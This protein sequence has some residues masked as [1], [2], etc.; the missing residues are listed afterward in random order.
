MSTFIALVL[1]NDALQNRLTNYS[2]YHVVSQEAKCVLMG[3]L[4]SVQ[5]TQTVDS[6]E[7]ARVVDNKKN[8]HFLCFH[9][10]SRIFLFAIQETR[11]EFLPHKT[12]TQQLKYSLVVYVVEWGSE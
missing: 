9:L 6:I 4:A 7:L 3:A 12:N 11:R 8:A 10:L 5:L 1:R 2:I